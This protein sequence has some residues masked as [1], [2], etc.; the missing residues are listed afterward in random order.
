MIKTYAPETKKNI[1]QVIDVFRDYIQ[2]S[3]H[4]ELVWSHKMGCYIYINIAS[5]I[6]DDMTCW[7]V[8]CAEELLDKLISE[9]A[10]DTMEAVGHTID[11]T[12]ATLLERREIARRLHPYLRQLPAYQDRLQ[13][14]LAGE[15]D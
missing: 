6:L 4:L 7:T 8:D 9:V 1:E 12:E 15:I 13:R 11:L 3:P 10:M 14:I 2:L 5:E